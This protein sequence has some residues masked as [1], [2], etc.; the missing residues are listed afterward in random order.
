ASDG[1]PRVNRINGDA[2]YTIYNV[3]F[4]AG[5]NLGSADLYAFGSYGNRSARSNQ[6]YRVGNRVSGTTSTGVTVYPLPNGFTPQE[7]VRE[8]DFSLTAGIKGK[9]AGWNYDLSGTYGRDTVKL[10]TLN[11][12]NRGLFSALQSTSA[13]PLTGLQRD[14]YDGQLSNS[15]WA[16]NLD[17]SREFE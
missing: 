1:F 4:S 10:Y 13:T 3:S 11:S 6:N 9:A 15:E 2:R 5:Y 17:L 14:F 7:G 16:A 12:A 8:E